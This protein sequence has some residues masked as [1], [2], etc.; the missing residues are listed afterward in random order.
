MLISVCSRPPMGGELWS[1]FQWRSSLKAF[2]I[3]ISSILRPKSG[4]R[5]SD[6]LGF[7]EVGG[8]WR[9]GLPQ[10]IVP[11]RVPI[12][13]VHRDPLSSWNNRRNT[14][15]VYV[16]HAS[17]W[18]TRKKKKKTLWL[19]FSSV[20]LF[21]WHWE[22]KYKWIKIQED[23]PFFCL[24]FKQNIFRAMTSIDTGT[25]FHNVGTEVALHF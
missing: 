17:S 24:D 7:V 2:C 12:P 16:V 18:K 14:W 19:W 10:A 23:A 3:S 22:Q 5:E 8:R 20:L 4:Y 15:G 21:H 25:V 6:R 13:A 9:V 1:D 11:I